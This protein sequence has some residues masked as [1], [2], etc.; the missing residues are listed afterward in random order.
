MYACGKDAYGNRK[1][2]AK[3]KCGGVLRSLPGSRS[4]LPEDSALHVLRWYLTTYGE[5]WRDA[6][7]ARKRKAWRVWHSARLGGWC[8]RVWLYGEPCEVRECR[9]VRGR[10]RLGPRLAVFPSRQAAVR[11]LWRFVRDTLGLLSL[12]AVWRVGAAPPEA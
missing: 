3:I 5:R 12:V 7:A 9:R 11:G 10:V 2:V 6:L 8:A 1:Y 4:A